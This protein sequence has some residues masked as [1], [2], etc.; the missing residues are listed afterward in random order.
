MRSCK[1]FLLLLFLGIS[2]LFVSAPTFAG[3]ILFQDDLE[4]HALNDLLYTPVAPTVGMPYTANVPYSRVVDDTLAPSTM[5]RPGQYAYKSTLSQSNYYDWLDFT[6][7]GT[8]ATTDKVVRISMDIN[9]FSGSSSNPLDGMV[10]Y[11]YNGG[12]DWQWKMQKDGTF[13][14]WD[15]GSHYTVLGTYSTDTWVD[16]EMLADYATKTFTLTVDG[17]TCPNL[18]F[19]AP[20]ANQ[21]SRIIMG[22]ATITSLYGW[23]DMVIDV[24]PEPS[25][26]ALLISGLVGLLAYAWRKRK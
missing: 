25:S 15:T 8:A 23:D 5:Y 1:L 12:Y 16:V 7:A 10:M 2:V 21:E 11:N 20:G 13:G 4:G 18:L 3:T 26:V 14:Y 17:T 24:V 22:P 9:M 19:Y 6:A